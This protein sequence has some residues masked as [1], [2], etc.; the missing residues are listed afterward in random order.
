MD[1]LRQWAVAVSGDTLS[2][3]VVKFSLS[4][5]VPVVGGVLS[6]AYNTVVGCSGLLRSTV[7]AF[8]VLAVVLVVLPP[9]LTCVCWNVGLHLAGGT[10]AL[11]GLTSLDTLCRTAAG[12]VKV[13]IALLAV[14]ALVMILSVSV[15]AS[16]GG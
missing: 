6:E 3:R 2:G 13:L 7:G 11:F 15:V 14:F 1:S 12:A 4:S 10:A 8:G 9:L 5:F 16:L